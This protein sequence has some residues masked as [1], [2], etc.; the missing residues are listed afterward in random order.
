MH[1]C[2]CLG[3]ENVSTVS[4]QEILSVFCGICLARSATVEVCTFLIEPTS[5]LNA[6]QYRLP[7]SH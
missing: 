7:S 4:R 3:A 6:A 2:D 5:L 1:M